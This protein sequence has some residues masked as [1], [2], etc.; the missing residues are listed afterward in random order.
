[1]K[2]VPLLA[3]FLSYGNSYMKCGKAF[4]KSYIF[5]KHSNCLNLLVL[6]EKICLTHFG[7]PQDVIDDLKIHTLIVESQGLSSRP[8]PMTEYI[9]LSMGFY[10]LA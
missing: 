3:F 5:V 7:I 2:T 4:Y 6:K 8:S 9:A 10:S 1:M